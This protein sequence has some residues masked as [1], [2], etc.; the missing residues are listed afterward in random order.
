MGGPAHRPS[1]ATAAR[2]RLVAPPGARHRADRTRPPRGR[3]PRV[4]RGRTHGRRAGPR[5]DRDLRSGDRL[6][7][8]PLERDRLRAHTRAH[9]PT[10]V[11][12]HVRTHRRSAR[13][14]PVR[15]AVAELRRLTAS[16]LARLALAA[17]VL[18]P[19]L[20]GGLYLY[21]NHD[22][23]GAFPQVPAAV[24]SDDA[25]TTLGTGERLQVGGE[26]AD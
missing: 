13:M 9:T 26:V 4:V 17:L 25:G 20:Y 3:P 18:V 11:R 10:H 23:Y 22:P 8:E 16:R 24:V 15:L 12:T 7:P 1:H 6:R 2:A 19:T 21:A 14:N 5:R